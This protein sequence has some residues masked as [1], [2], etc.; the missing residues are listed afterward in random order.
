MLRHMVLQ[1]LPGRRGV[2]LQVLVT[3]YELIM[4]QED[5]ARLGALRWE[6]LVVDEAH[7]LKN[8]A[9]RLRAQLQ[10]LRYKH[11]LLLTGGLGPG[12]EEPLFLGSWLRDML[13]LVLLAASACQA[14]NQGHIRGLWVT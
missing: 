7:R 12:V 13:L 14:L 11:I 2:R 10:Q 8:A 3:S 4:G 5:V 9:S 6:Y 1:V